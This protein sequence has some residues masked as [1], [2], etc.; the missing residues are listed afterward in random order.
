M[1]TQTTGQTETRTGYRYDA[2]V[3]H[4]HEADPETGIAL[5]GG[6]VGSWV[7]SRPVAGKPCRECRRIL[8]ATMDALCMCG[9]TGSH[10]CVAG[11]PVPAA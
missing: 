1:S 3:L 8:A 2:G 6:H 11:T 10:Y 4:R 9:E 5:C 7:E